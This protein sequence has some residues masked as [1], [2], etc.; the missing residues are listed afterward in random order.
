MKKEEQIQ[1]A[2]KV[3]EDLRNA[4]NDIEEMIDDFVDFDENMEG[5]GPLEN[6]GDGIE[7]LG[8]SNNMEGKFL[9]LLFYRKYLAYTKTI[10]KK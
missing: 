1:R 10:Q 2:R 7:F 8:A 5:V 4:A 9:L 6:I 3:V